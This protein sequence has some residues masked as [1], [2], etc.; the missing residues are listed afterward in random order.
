I[1][2]CD[3]RDNALG[4]IG[5]VHR[6]PTEDSADMEASKAHIMSLLRHQPGVTPSQ[7]K[8]FE[9]SLPSLLAKR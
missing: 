9:A 2:I 5:S 8:A 3:K 7:L 6:I 4:L 1:L